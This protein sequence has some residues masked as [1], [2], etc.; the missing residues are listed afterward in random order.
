MFTADQIK[1]VH[2]NVK[3]GADFPAYIQK[4]KELGV[5]SYDTYVSDGHSEFRG[6]QD[7]K[8]SS[9]A[10]YES[11][12][13]AEKCNAAKFRDDLKAHQGGKSDYLT[14]IK[15]AAELGIKK[16][17]VSISDL[18]C[19]YYDQAGNEVLIENIPHP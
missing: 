15:T 6:Q 5:V 2:S 8:T 19:T 11:L 16:W 1:K 10:A 17:S 14:F 12:H 3:S 7:Y 9:P 18:T 13:I 4:I